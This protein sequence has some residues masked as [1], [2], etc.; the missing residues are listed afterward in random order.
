MRP[1]MAGK[2]SMASLKDGSLDIVDVAQLN[3]A[4]DVLDENRRRLDEAQ[5]ARRG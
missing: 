4:L 2:C 1:V 3:D 5:A